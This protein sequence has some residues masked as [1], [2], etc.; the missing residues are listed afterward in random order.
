MHRLV[1]VAKIS[2]ILLYCTPFDTADAHCIVDF[3]M[4]GSIDL[5]YP[6]Q[7]DDLIA[8]SIIIIMRRSCSDG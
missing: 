1:V 8:A 7:D 3:V 4:K 2:L 6:V 5:L